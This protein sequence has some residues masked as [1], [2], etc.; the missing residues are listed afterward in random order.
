VGWRIFFF[1]HLGWRILKWHGTGGWFVRV[2]VCLCVFGRGVDCYLLGS[3]LVYTIG[4]WCCNEN[5]IHFLSLGPT[6]VSQYGCVRRFST[7]NNRSGP[8]RRAR[9]LLVDSSYK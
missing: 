8:R 4:F 3:W 2:G 5:M 6:S 1:F 9:G 7:I